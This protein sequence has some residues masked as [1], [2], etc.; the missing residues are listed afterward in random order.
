MEFPSAILSV[1]GKK[2]SDLGFSVENTKGWER[3]ALW[4]RPSDLPCR[5]SCLPPLPLRLLANRALLIHLL[6]LLRAQTSIPAH[7]SANQ[8]EPMFR[9]LLASSRSIVA[10]RIGYSA[11]LV[12]TCRN[13]R[14]GGAPLLL[15]LLQFLQSEG[16]P[17]FMICMSAWFHRSRHQN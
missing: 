16:S 6:L 9:G 5:W 14:H 15:Y 8:G 13:G 2:H 12:V 7:P 11:S 3:M 17:R 4:D 10:K 1:A